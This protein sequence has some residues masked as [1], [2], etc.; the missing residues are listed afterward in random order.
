VSQPGLCFGAAGDEFNVNN[1]ISLKCLYMEVYPKQAT[2][3][4]TGNTV[5]R[6]HRHLLHYSTHRSV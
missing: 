1:V 5:S 2:H 4:E 6:A 3:I